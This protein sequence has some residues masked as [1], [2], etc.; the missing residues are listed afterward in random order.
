MRRVRGEV[1]WVCEAGVLERETEWEE[2]EKK[3][4]RGE[5]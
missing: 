3:W 1:R 4:R 5:E 2:S